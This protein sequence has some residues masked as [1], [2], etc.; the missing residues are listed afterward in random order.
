VRIERSVTSGYFRLRALVRAAFRAAAER[1]APARRAWRDIARRDTV[2]DPLD[3]SRKYLHLGHRQGSSHT[4]VVLADQRIKRG[5]IGRGPGLDRQGRRCAPSRWR[6]FQDLIPFEGF[7][8]PFG[9]RLSATD[10]MNEVRW[11]PTACHLVE[12]T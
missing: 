7:G 5:W 2:P 10:R 9:A 8:L 11:N 12:K 3:K 4:N 1:R 6:P